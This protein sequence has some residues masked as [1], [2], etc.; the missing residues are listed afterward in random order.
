MPSQRP[1]HRF[2]VEQALLDH[3]DRLY[4]HSFRGDSGRLHP[5]FLR[6]GEF[7]VGTVELKLDSDEC[8]NHASRR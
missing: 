4:I 8:G 7:V 1:I 2:H 6:V 3:S 5:G